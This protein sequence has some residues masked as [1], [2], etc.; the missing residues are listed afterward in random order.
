[1][2]NYLLD[3]CALIAFF[4]GEEGEPVVKE[5]LH[6]ARRGEIAIS[7]HAANLIEVYMEFTKSKLAKM[8]FV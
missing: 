1:M 7:I 6:R 2:Q 3:A 4:D 5:L 8:G